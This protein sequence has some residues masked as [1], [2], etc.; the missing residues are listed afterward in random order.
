M[1]KIFCCSCLK[2]SLL[3]TKHYFDNSGIHGLHYIT[4]PKRHF[5]ERLFWCAVCT[6]ASLATFNTLIITWY[7]FQHNAVN[8][9]V[10][11]AYL[12]WNTTFPSISV[13]EN[14]APDKIFDSG[15][16]LYGEDRNMNI[17]FFVRDV[18]FF[19]GTCNSCSVHCGITVNCS[20]NLDGIVSGVRATCDDYIDDCSWNGVPFNCCLHFLPLKTEIG[21]CY[22]LNS[23]HTKSAEGVEKLELISNQQ[24][25]PGRLEFS[26]FEATKL[27][28]HSKDDVPSLNHPQEEKI[29]LN[30]GVSLDMVV[31]VTEIENDP[32]LEEVSVVQRNCRFPEENILRTYD[33]YSYS[34]C[35]VDC[36]TSLGIK[37]CN[38]T[39][40]FMPKIPGIKTCGIA[41]LACLTQHSEILRTLKPKGSAKPGLDCDCMSSCT[42]PEYTVV[43]KNSPQD[44]KIEGTRI[45][46]AMDALPAH[47]F[48]RNVVRTKLDLVVSMGGTIGLFLGMSLLS[49][50]EWFYFMFVRKWTHCEESAETKLGK[51]VIFRPT[52]AVGLRNDDF[53]PFI[54]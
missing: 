36:R 54:R 15:S 7:N 53:L 50:V 41:G 46:I 39:H 26:V 6:L 21:V 17:D 44:D 8:F 33:Y 29:I 16:S 25:G 28:I 13:C 45:S 10:T 32:N 11:T 9:G 34:A 3:R 40:H 35:V 49:F 2:R 38:C 47:R 18:A 1:D 48:K 19:D 5:T 52:P 31:H 4:E 12:E 24:T 37:L 14:E 20:E 22:S 42:E 30:W 51:S 27:F 43:S 23:V